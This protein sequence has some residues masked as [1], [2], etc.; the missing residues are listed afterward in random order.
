[1]ATIN[2][3]Q[4]RGYTSQCTHCIQNI[5][6]RGKMCT[7]LCDTRAARKS[8]KWHF[9]SLI[10]ANFL[11]KYQSVWLFPIKKGLTWE[12]CV[13]WTTRHG[14][15]SA[16]GKIYGS[17]TGCMSKVSFGKMLNP[18]LLWMAAPSAGEWS[19]YAAYLL[20]SRLATLQYVWMRH[21]M[22]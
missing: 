7:D 19:E 12:T 3:A 13:C 9:M 11:M 14:Q 8:S 18:K 16:D 15:L 22:Q 17:V 6:F 1:M 10:L 21:I 20:M 5:E 4:Y 2:G